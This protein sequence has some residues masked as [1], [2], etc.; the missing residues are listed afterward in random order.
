M[1]QTALEILVAIEME[2]ERMGVPLVCF[3]YSCLEIQYDRVAAVKGFR[4]L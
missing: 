4:I 3:K 1:E 2:S